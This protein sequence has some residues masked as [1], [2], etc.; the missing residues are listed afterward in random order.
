M[1]IISDFLRLILIGILLKIPRC[2]FSG[3]SLE[4]FLSKESVTF[5]SFIPSKFQ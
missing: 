5:W 2:G 1:P 4:V 3:D